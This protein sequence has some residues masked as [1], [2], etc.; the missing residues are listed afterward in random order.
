MKN[1][2]GVE[3]SIISSSKRTTAKWEKWNYV[4]IKILQKNKTNEKSTTD[5]KSTK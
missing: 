1:H 3:F 4:S 2:H 5:E